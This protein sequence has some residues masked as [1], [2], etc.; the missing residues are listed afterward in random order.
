MVR[1]L[2][3]LGRSDRRPLL[4][5]ERALAGCRLSADGDLQRHLESAIFV[6]VNDFETVR[7]PHD[8]R[9]GDWALCRHAQ[10][11]GRV[12]AEVERLQG[13]YDQRAEHIRSE[14]SRLVQID[15]ARDKAEAEVE[16]LRAALER[17]A[18]PEIVSMDDGRAIQAD[19][20]AA[21][22]EEKV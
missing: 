4:A 11:L 7:E 17:I 16:R 19:A 8:I 12:E 13:L 15:A 20:R 2:A 6:R 21:L 1:A 18:E 10:A 5:D 9:C 14:S 3:D 22:A